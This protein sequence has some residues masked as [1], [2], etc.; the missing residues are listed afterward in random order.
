MDAWEYIA[1]VEKEENSRSSKVDS[2]PKEIGH[3]DF[4]D[5]KKTGMTTLKL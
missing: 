4:D 1:S 3:D 5:E 2:A